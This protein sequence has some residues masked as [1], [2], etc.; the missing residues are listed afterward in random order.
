[1]RPSFPQLK[2]QS[3]F[4]TV[5]WE[6]LLSGEYVVTHCSGFDPNYSVDVH[7]FMNEIDVYFWGEGGTAGN[8]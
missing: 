3:F 5:D 4:N 7:V 6:H 1:M 2:E 8:L